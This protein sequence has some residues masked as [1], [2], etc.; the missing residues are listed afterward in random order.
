MSPNCALLNF[1]FIYLK[2]TN[3]VVIFIEKKISYC[4]LN[5]NDSGLM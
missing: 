4:I 3:I 1:F 5:K 2:R